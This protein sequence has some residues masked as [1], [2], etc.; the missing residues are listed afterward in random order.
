MVNLNVSAGHRKLST[1]CCLK[2]NNILTCQR[3]VSPDIFSQCDFP[4]VT[5]VLPGL[6]VP[7]DLHQGCAFWDNLP[8]PALPDRI[9]PCVSSELS[10]IERV[11]T[12]VSAVCSA[13]WLRSPLRFSQLLSCWCAT[14][15]P[16]LHSCWGPWLVHIDE[17]VLRFIWIYSK[18]Y[19]SRIAK[20]SVLP[21]GW[22]DLMCSLT[23]GIL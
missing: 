5:C 11:W 19:M 3:I 12:L 18:L 15:P 4:T 13:G 9:S 22:R 17:L 8:V 1:A 2:K 21:Y 20:T 23:H 16:D 6:S 14:K 7:A 10:L